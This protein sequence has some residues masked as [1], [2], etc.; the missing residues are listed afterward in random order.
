MFPSSQDPALNQEKEKKDINNEKLPKELQI[1]LKFLLEKYEKEDDYVRKQ[2]IKTWKKADEFW[3]GIQFVFWSESRQNWISPTET[4]WFSQEEGREESEGPFYDFVINIYKAHGESIIAALG[5]QIPGV[6]F[7][8]DD[9]D[10][11]EDIMTSRTYSKI[12]DLIQRHNDAKVTYLMALFMLWNQGLV[13]AYHAPK[14]DRAFGK[15]N[16]PKYKQG[17]TCPNCQEQKPVDEDNDE[18]IDT[19]AGSPCP[20]C[21]TMMQMGTVLDGFSDA[22]KTRVLIDIY[23]PLFVKVPY[24]ARTQKDFK[25]LCFGIDQPKAL[26]K[27]LYPDIKDEINADQ[28]DMMQFERMARSPS[29]YSAASRVDENRDLTTFRRCWIRPWAFEDLGPEK[30]EEI[31][32]LKKL[33]PHGCYMA[34]IG[35]TYA[36]ARDEDLDKYWTIGKA[37][38]ST[39]IHSDPLGQPLMPVQEMTN[40]MRNLTLET[41]EQ[42]IPST[43]ADPEVIDFNNYARHEA[44]PGMVY[45]A[46]KRLGEKM[47]DSFYEGGRATL[48]GEV[49]V[50]GQ[51][52]ERDGQF[53]T[54][55][56]PSI[57]GGATDAKS[58]TAAEYNMSRQMALQR[59]SI[60]WTF[61]TSWW[62]KMMEK[63]VHLYVDNM[64]SDEK[65]TTRENND[66]VSVWIRKSEATGHVGDVEP[67]GSDS[68]PISMPQK[69]AMF[70]KLLDL[71]DDMLHA[72]MFDPSNRKTFADIMGFP[73]LEIPGENQRIKQS[74]ETAMMMQGQPV[75]IEPGL[76][77]DDIHIFTLR[78]YLVDSVG[79]DAKQTNPQGYELCKQH[80][81]EHEKS[82]QAAKDQEMQKQMQMQMQME[83]QRANSSMKREI[84]KNSMKAQNPKV[85]KPNPQGPG[86]Q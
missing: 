15:I 68:F 13:C 73:D 45:P 85:T 27:D 67:E 44:R 38:L 84:L 30:E 77:D 78:N 25:Y 40:V 62:A 14:A 57:Y 82:A 61:V 6:R 20:T 43:F 41:I 81:Q 69:Q 63:C 32:K 8:P 11:D 55:S 53:V 21:G 5:A 23:G 34:F 66:Y 60:V 74:R 72:A 46:R 35:S 42:G 71:K 10:D 4:R 7:P 19:E 79:L 48:S 37:G 49:P 47:S 17:L 76:D 12:A 64:I 58:R 59:L 36:E 2:Q 28:S 70:L 9:A 16:I 33:F 52:L 80:L 31:K 18:E 22:P 29:T 3:S 50:F 83:E 75:P 86:V 39:Y 56:F 65:Y 51:Q 1:C 54:G 24:H 26:M